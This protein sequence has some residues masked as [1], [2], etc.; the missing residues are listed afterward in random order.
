MEQIS[1]LAALEY[2][3]FDAW[4]SFRNVSARLCGSFECTDEL[5]VDALILLHLALIE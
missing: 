4:N 2:L 5:R 3:D 1:E